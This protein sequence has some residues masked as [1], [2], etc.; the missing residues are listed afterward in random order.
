MA[1]F[2]HLHVHSYFSLLDGCASPVELARAAAEAGMPALALTDHDALYGAIEFYD[3]CQE[4]GILPVV[5]MELTVDTNA[6]LPDSLVLLARDLKGYANLCHL[7][8]A[9]QTHPERDLAVQSGLPVDELEGR[10]G[11]LI[12]LTGGKRGRLDQL[13]RAGQNEQA[14]AVAAGWSERFGRE[15]TFVELQ[16]Q[17]LGDGEVA[18]GLSALAARL[19]LLTVATNNVHYLTP[20]GAVKRRLVTAMSE[21]KRLEL[22]PRRPGLHL[23][24][25]VEM[26]VN[27]EGLPGATANTLAVARECRLQLPLGQPAFPEIELPPGQKAGD[28]LRADALAGA[29]QRFGTVDDLVRSRLDHELTIIDSMGYSPL[30]LIVADVV[31]FA[32]E[33][34]VPINLRGSAASSLV[35]YCLGIS[36]VDPIALDLYFE[37][38]LNPERRDPPDIDLDLCSRRR[39]EVIRYIYE[40]YGEDRVATICTY[41][42]LRARSAWREVGKAYG[43]PQSRI[44]SVAREIPRFFHPGMVPQVSQAQAQLLAQAQTEREQEALAAAWALDR[45][46]RHLSVHPGGVVI[47]PGRLS[48]LVPLQLATKGLIITQ[49]DLH[50]IERLGLVKIDLLGIRALTVVADSIERIQRQHAYFSRDSIPDGDATTGDMLARAATIGCFQIE[51]PGMRRTLRELGTRTVQDVTVS[52]ALYKP[53]PMRGGLKD[54]FVRRH[55]GEE[56]TEYLHPALEPILRSTHGVVLYQEQVLRIA[57]ELAGFSLG[58]ADTLRRAIGHLGR[59]EEMVPLRDEFIERVGRVSGIPPDVA[60]RLWELMESFAGYGFLKAHASSYAVVAY[61]T[62]YLKAHYPAEFLTAV[63]RNWGGYYPQRVFLGEA[64]RLGLEVRPPHVNH[65]VRRFELEAGA[66]GRPVLWMG[67]NQIRELRRTT[68]SAI[69]A[70]REERPFTS[71]DDL[72]QSVRPRMAEAENMVK[73][74]AL[75][76]LGAGR[77]ALLAQLAGRLTGAP[78]QMA[79]PLGFG[80]EGE[81]AREGFSLAEQL[82]LEVEMLGW[83][84]SAHPLKPY[85]RALKQRGVIQ[86]D[87]L[88][89]EIGSRVL[90]AG[91]RMGLWGERRGHLT[92]E[93]E[94][95]LFAVHLPQGRRLQPGIMG[96]LGPYLAHGRVQLGHGD[97]PVILVDRIEPLGA[98]RD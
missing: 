25:P 83:P 12:A 32:R 17:E 29:G 56:A 86:S 74:G 66:K 54:A 6:S 48:D 11:G 2:V 33:K 62:A 40:R 14:E 27:F 52:L 5:G 84:A 22:I 60:T 77:K 81:G 8:S 7:S 43:L 34:G 21:L 97:E 41:T 42:R 64:R 39:D 69:L 20:E 28:V 96:R 91:A 63:L 80:L 47:A 65:S 19:G 82:A 76:G 45:H 70:A 24:S 16:I 53:G 92:F 59:G 90:V 38:F 3:A 31:R 1:D 75:D 4:A 18:G 10:L 58:E 13:V 89:E 98:V 79:L 73:A 30:F 35:A 87:A 50:S 51:S 55:R 85:A 71:L 94:T 36:S 26:R 72:L 67:L 88:H 37:R 78:L 23:A 15:N 9:L 44:S 49:Y 46:P 57:H 61:Q 93:D 95:G 68:I